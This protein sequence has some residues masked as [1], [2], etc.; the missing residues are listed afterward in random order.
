MARMHPAVAEYDLPREIAEEHV[1]SLAEGLPDEVV[2]FTQ[3]HLIDQHGKNREID[4]LVAW[5]GLG[6][7]VVEVK[8]GR[9]TVTDGQWFSR[10]ARGVNN[11]IQDPVQQAEKAMWALKHYVTTRPEWTDIWPPAVVPVAALPWSQVVEGFR[12]PGA[13]AEQ[14][15]DERACA[16]TAAFG[17][18]LRAA[19][20]AARPDVYAET[21]QLQV[22]LLV[23][24][25][26]V[27][28]PAQTDLT[29]LLAE[30]D[31]VVTLLTRR[32]YGTLE[33]IRANDRII[34][35]GGPGTGKT[36]LAL[37]HA[38]QEAERGARV[39]LVCYSRGLAE[40]LRTV[41]SSW[42]VEQQP[43]Y[44]G[45]FHYLAEQWS[46]AA[47]GGDTAYFDSLPGRL[48]EAAAAREPDERFD[49]LI[50]D[51]AQDFSD[52]WWPPLLATLGDPA[53]GPVVVFQDDLQRIFAGRGHLPFTGVEVELDENLRNTQEIAAVFDSLRGRPVKA[54]GPDGPPARLVP[55][56]DRRAID[57][58]DRVVTRLIAEG[59]PP[60]SI[61]VLTTY[62]RHPVHDRLFR[63]EGP[64]AYWRTFDSDEVFYATVQS[65]KGLERPVVVLTVN[66]FNF[67]A[68]E[69]EILHVG[70]SRA[71]SLL[72]VVADPTTLAGV[73]GGEVALTRLE[74][75]PWT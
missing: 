12:T 14:F 33:K 69:R 65:F 49:L 58:A 6:L 41:T 54:R 11:S 73:E 37:E 39:G 20:E 16:D 30:H 4:L 31:A 5:P 68:V 75:R 36:F 61:S 71:R 60:S 22:D 23:S 47:P 19:L 56:T 46:D 29:G 7:A 63:D 40:F 62:R 8:G 13:L 10:N 24:M 18:A 44:A 52:D 72:V 27:S 32:Q 28:L 53:D 43:A 55:S 26:E 50:V 1:R 64:A 67:D 57:D 25:L 48:A 2:C 21:T 45:T 74:A 38:R 34:V 17:E 66:G 51:E 35:K 59:Y 15:L 70:M 9:V 3:V 42:D